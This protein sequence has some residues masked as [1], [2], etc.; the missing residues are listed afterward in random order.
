MSTP[1]PTPPES[2]CAVVVTYDRPALLAKCLATLRA[3]TRAPEHVVVVDNASPSEVGEIVD[4]EYPEATL[5]RLP[6]N[7]G[8]AGGFAA[9]MAWA[10]EAG[11]GWLWIMD[12]DAFPRPDCL[13][14]LLAEQHRGPVLVPVLTDSLGRWNNIGTGLGAARNRTPA[15]V[16][17][18]EPEVGDFTYT[19]V[20]PLFRRDVVERVGLPRADFF[21]W[22]DDFEYALRIHEAFPSATVAVP[23][24]VVFHESGSAA[25][26]VTRWG[27]RSLREAHAPWKLYYMARNQ[28]YSALRLH[29]SRTAF[30]DYAR[31]QLR[32]ALGDLVYEPD[33]WHRLGMRLRGAWDGLRGQLGRHPRWP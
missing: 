3:Q 16:A 5:V 12:D 20:G 4:A 15:L 8:G 2:V 31:V 29:P 19:F 13:E 14:R 32:Y 18:G 28:L 25:R 21:I 30:A 33:G 7:V 17:R 6:E 23:G 1:P 22:F 26:E 24:A 10:L 11:Y 9:G 27:R